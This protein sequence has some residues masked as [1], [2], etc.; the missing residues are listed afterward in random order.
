MRGLGFEPGTAA[1]LNCL[2]EKQQAENPPLLETPYHP[3]PYI[4]I[5]C[6]DNTKGKCSRTSC[7]YL[8]I[9]PNIRQQQQQ[10]KQQRFRRRRMKE[11]KDKKEDNHIFN[12]Q[13]KG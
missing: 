13:G 1:I 12:A 6:R 3:A 5:V 11:K 4:H 10:L 2:I 8:H 9:Y 7:K